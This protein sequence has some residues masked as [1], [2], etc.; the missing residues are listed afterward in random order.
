[1]FWCFVF[2]LDIMD[3]N[4]CNEDKPSLKGCHTFEIRSFICA[5]EA[6]LLTGQ[7]TNWDGDPL[8]CTCLSVFIMTHIADGKSLISPDSSWSD[9]ENMCLSFHRSMLEVPWRR[10]SGRFYEE[11]EILWGPAH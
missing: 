7:M 1:M 10:F 11:N 3:I 9:L 4:E 6:D 2:A 8:Y 5:H